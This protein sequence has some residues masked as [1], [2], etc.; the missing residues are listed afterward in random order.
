M[1]RQ[2]SRHVE[3]RDHLVVPPTMDKDLHRVPAI[4]LSLQ[5]RLITDVEAE[6]QR[7]AGPKYPLEMREDR[8]DLV[9]GDVNQRVPGDQAGHG[10]VGEGEV[11]HGAKIEPET[12]MVTPCHLDHP[13]RQVDPE[14]VHAQL[15]QVGRD[16][17]RPASHVRNAPP[18]LDAHHVREQRQDRALLRRFIQQ[19]TSQVRITISDGV[20]RRP[21]IFQPAA[22]ARSRFHDRR[23]PNSPNG[24]TS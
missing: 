14:R 12:R 20:V 4:A 9:V 6:Q 1:S 2:R 16:P 3:P 19:V 24:R 21:R 11:R 15:T 8:A 17:P 13:G 5:L 7:P 22:S 23:L 18:A 10:G